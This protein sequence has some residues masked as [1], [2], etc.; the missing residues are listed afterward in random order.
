MMS[1]RLLERGMKG[2]ATMLA[3][4]L[5]VACGSSEPP[6]GARNSAATKNASAK[7]KK[8][9]ATAEEVAVEARGKV[10]CPAKTSL[11]A[12]AANAPVDDIVGVRP[13]M[14]YDEA[15]NVVMCSHKLLVVTED[16]RGRFKINTYG[17]KLRMGFGAEF[18]QPR[19]T[20]QKTA[21]EWAQELQY[22]DRNRGNQQLAGGTSRWYV[23][24]MGIPGD[25]R[26]VHAS[27]EEAYE[28]GR[29]PTVDSVVSALIAKYGEPTRRTKVQNNGEVHLN[30]NH[31][32]FGRRIGETS[33]LY[34]SCN[35]VAHFGAALFFT[36]DCGISIAARLL[37]VRENH[38]LASSLQVTVVD[39]G[40]AYDAIQKTEQWFAQQ[41]AQRRA[42]EIEAAGKNAGAPTL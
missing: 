28:E 22:G 11:P 16:L 37:P 29:Q 7:S 1:N 35:S 15:A 18:A 17:Q 34:N 31:D 21:R 39:M 4:G 13:G 3:F 9:D 26:V 40:G 5:L 2:L 12:R 6:P 24:T 36:P 14:K 20:V 10:K 23:G 19:V 25:E 41:D 33:A 30:W 8:P 27:R 32:P 38:A 42:K